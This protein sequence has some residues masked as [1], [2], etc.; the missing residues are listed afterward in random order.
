MFSNH[1]P[2]APTPRAQGNPALLYRFLGI[3]MVIIA[4]VLI[5]A[6]QSGVVGD[7]TENT[8][9]PAYALSAVSFLMCAAALIVLKPLVPT[10]HAGQTIAAYWTNRSAS[11]KAAR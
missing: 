4:A 2:A 1:A 10:R 7:L 6:R 3:G 9:V 5:I 8:P 11:S